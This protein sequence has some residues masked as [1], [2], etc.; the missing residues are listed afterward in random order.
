[1]PGTHGEADN[2]AYV[3]AAADVEVAGEEGRQVYGI[4]GIRQ[5]LMA[6]VDGWESR[7]YK[8]HEMMIMRLGDM[9]YLSRQRR[10]LQQCWCQV[11]LVQRL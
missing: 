6:P 3:A 2:G 5:M 4:E 9:T 10:N 8:V 7:E 1:M 11:A